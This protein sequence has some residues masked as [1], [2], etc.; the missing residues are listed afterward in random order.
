M[1]ESFILWIICGNGALSQNC[2]ILKTYGWEEILRDY[3]AQSSHFLVK[4]TEALERR[5]LP[6]ITWLGRA[7]AGSPAH[8]LPEAQSPWNLLWGSNETHILMSEEHLKNT[9]EVNL[10]WQPWSILYSK[11]RQKCQKIVCGDTH[12]IRATGPYLGKGIGGVWLMVLCFLINLNYV[13]D[14]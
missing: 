4:E 10:L 5:D 11:V 7:S 13:R 9:V 1:C 14:F 12:L 6:R 8:K 2:R 3:W